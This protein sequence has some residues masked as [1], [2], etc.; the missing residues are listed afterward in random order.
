MH[1]KKSRTNIPQRF[2]FERPIGPIGLSNKN[3]WECWCEN[4]Y[5]ASCGRGLTW[6]YLRKIGRVNKKKSKAV[7]TDGSSD[8]SWL[9]F[10]YCRVSVF[11]V[12][13]DKRKSAVA[14]AN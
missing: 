9:N 14:E 4:F 8:I 2:L 10:S 5:S 1:C 6:S 12:A 13:G 11:A 7:V 3:L